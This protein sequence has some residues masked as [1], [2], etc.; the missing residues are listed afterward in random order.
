MTLVLIAA[1]KKINWTQ[2][3]SRRTVKFYTVASSG[4]PSPSP[5]LN[6]QIDAAL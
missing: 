6:F 3:E 1:I 4:R 5:R 2:G